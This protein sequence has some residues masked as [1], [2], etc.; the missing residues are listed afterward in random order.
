MTGR[1]KGN[2]VFIPRI[3]LTPSDSGLPFDLKR[4]QFPVRA[5]FAMSMNKTQDQTL[6]F[7]GLDLSNEVFTHGQLY[8]ALSR[9]KSFQS[10][11]ILP[12]LNLKVAGFFFHRQHCLQ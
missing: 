8:D 9:V 12:N 6:D 10:L 2:C 3:T 1:K 4:R 11:S 5:A 7:V